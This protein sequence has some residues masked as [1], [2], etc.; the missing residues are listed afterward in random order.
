MYHPTTRLLTILEL[1]QTHPSLS[2]AALA[3][4]LEVDPRSVRRYIMMLQDMGMPIEATRGPGGGY[5]LRPG[6]KLPPLLFTDEE[7]TAIVLGLLGTV[8]LEIGQSAVAIEGALAKVLRVLPV[9]ARERLNAV[10][11]HVILS[12]HE[13]A[14]RPDATLLLNLSE[15]IQQRQQIAIAYQSQHDTVTQRTV[16][17]YGIAGW[18]GRWYLV[19]YCCLRQGYRAFRLD[20]M[21]QVRLLAETFERA[22]DFDCQAYVVEHIAKGKGGFQI[23]VEFQAP[24]ET[25]QQRIP[26]WYGTLAATPEGVLFQSQYGNISATALYLIGLNLPFVVHKPP[27]LQEA[28][29]E[30]A[31]QLIQSASPQHSPGH[32]RRIDQK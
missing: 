16:E 7:A 22:E 3:R 26:A 8:W 28:L 21:Q 1:L 32:A 15:A 2:G 9:R 5:Q 19:G 20:R 14:A 17:P 12:P 13:Q 31:R 10:A 30:L 18:W 24:L 29:R 11:A 25:V 6:F 4:R 23:E 27:E